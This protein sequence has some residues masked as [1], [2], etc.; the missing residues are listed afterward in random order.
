MI[1]I[2]KPISVTATGAAWIKYTFIGGDSCIGITPTGATV[3]GD[4][5]SISPTFTFTDSACVENSIILRIETDTNC[6]KDVSF[7]VENPCEDLVVTVSNNYDAGNPYVFAASVVGANQPYSVTWQYDTALFNLI[8]NTGVLKLDLKPGVV[9]PPSTTVRATVKD[10]LNCTASGQYTFSFQAPTAL[11][12]GGSFSCIPD[13]TIGGV[14]VAGQLTIVLEAVA[15]AGTTIDWDTV[16]IYNPFSDIVVEKVS[17]TIYQLFSKTRVAAFTRVL[18]WD[19]KNNLGIISNRASI[20]ANV[21]SCDGSATPIKFLNKTVKLT[22]AETVIAEIKYI[23]ISELIIGGAGPDWDTFTFK[24]GTGQTLVS[25]TSLTTQNGTVELTTGRQL[26]YTVTGTVIPADP[27]MMTIE[28]LNGVLS[29]TGTV[30]VDFE[31]DVAPTVANQAVD[32]ATGSSVTVDLLSAATGSPV[33]STIIVTTY[34]TLGTYSI[35]T[36]GNMIYTP[37][38]SA[39]GTDTLGFIVANADGTYSAEGTIT[40]TIIHAGVNA[41]T[42]RCDGATTVNAET[43]LGTGVTAGGVWAADAGNPSVIGVGTP[44]ALDFSAATAGTYLFTYTVTSGTAT[45]VATITVVLSLYTVDHLITSVTS[46]D[47]AED[48]NY[49]VRF[50]V[51]PAN[52]PV[53]SLRVYLHKGASPLTTSSSNIIDAKNPTSYDAAN[54]IFE[55]VYSI[56]YP[57]TETDVLVFRGAAVTPCATTVEDYS[58]ELP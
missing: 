7:V 47:T 12:D 30:T 11:D 55:L 48:Y 1:T 19:V 16:T 22:P 51:T 27:I 8:Q 20:N 21:I 28:D 25:P 10:S 35:A 23:T 42:S 38:V 17:D 53:T 3:T 31:T 56:N 18:T 54:G 44:T 40:I 14:S 13:T 39:E 49:T 52:L 41:T 58:S 45:D 2:T 9:P 57:G 29:N 33:G 36:D 4:T 15:P 5:L 43:L 50:K 37:S 26:K 34:P 24:A 46:G 32:V 6:I